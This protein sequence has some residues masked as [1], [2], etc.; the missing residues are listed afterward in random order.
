MCL[1][2]EASWEQAAI[3]QLNTPIS[4]Q[5]PEQGWF[6]S[7]PFQMAWACPVWTSMIRSQQKAMLLPRRV[8]PTRNELLL[9]DDV[10]GDL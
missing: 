6:W 9:R 5:S 8:S 3:P 7:P 1:E 4:V 10:D 2:G